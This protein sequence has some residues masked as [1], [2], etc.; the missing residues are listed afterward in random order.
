[1]TPPQKRRNRIV[2]WHGSIVGKYLSLVIVSFAVTSVW[3][4]VL[5]RRFRLT[6]MLF[7]IKPATG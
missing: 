5:V 4:E 3:Y 1:V 2:R 6:R 7:G